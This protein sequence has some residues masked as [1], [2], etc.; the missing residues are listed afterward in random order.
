MQCVGRCGRDG[1]PAEAIM[2]FNNNDIAANVEG[3]DDK[4]GD[5]CRTSTCRWDFICSHFGCVQHRDKVLHSCCD[6][7]AVICDCEQCEGLL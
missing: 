1:S 5:Y 3:L 7:C 6:N 2:H 4:V